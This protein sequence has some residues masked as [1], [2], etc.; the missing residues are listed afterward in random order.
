[1]KLTKEYILECIEKYCDLESLDEDTFEYKVALALRDA[2]CFDCSWTWDCGVTKGVLIFSDLNFVVKIPFA[3]SGGYVES[4]YENRYGDWV[5]SRYETERTNAS[6]CGRRW[7]EAEDC[8]EQFS[9]ADCENG[10]DYCEVE[11]TR[12]CHAEQANV[13]ILFAKTEWIGDIRE[14]PIYIQERC[15]MFREESTSN[16]EK[17]QSRTKADYEKVNT[18]REKYDF[19]SIND[20][21]M[22]DFLIYYGEEMF[23]KLADFIFNENIYDLHNGNIGYLNGRPCL[24]DYSSYDC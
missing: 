11:A 2:E 1:M 14:Y 17:Y 21:W 4:H 24:V 9:G 8:F 6:T 16:Q 19:H 10:W 18:L 5:D 12:Y 20:D 3:G 7:V 22:L 23:K 15:Q 13:A